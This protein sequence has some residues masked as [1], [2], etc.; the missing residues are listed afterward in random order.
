ME[1]QENRPEDTNAYETPSWLFKLLD[2][3]F[4]FTIDAFA[5]EE[6]HKCGL[7]FTK[8]RCA[9]TNEWH[10]AA[11]G[12]ETQFRG[13]SVFANP[14]YSQNILGRSVRRMAEQSARHDTTVVALIP[15]NVGTSWWHEVV[16]TQASEVRFFKGRIAFEFCGNP[17]TMWD[18]K[19]EK[20]V[21]G[22][23]RGDSCLVIFRPYLHG[24]IFRTMR[25]A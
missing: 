2:F 7:Y 8:E 12:C 14:P 19:R 6:N 5:S 15:P 13:A 22:S 3:E 18:A 25:A 16:M 20:L 11:F 24:P 4:N 21:E 9:F 10:G 23:N 17:I 1:S